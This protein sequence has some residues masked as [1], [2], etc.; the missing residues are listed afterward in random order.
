MKLWS[1]RL[2]DC[3]LI[4]L[5]ILVLVVFFLQIRK[6]SEKRESFVNEA[7]PVVHFLTAEETSTFL[8]QDEDGYVQSLSKADLFARG[9]RSHAEYINKI[10]ASAAVF[11]KKDRALISHLVQKI[12][13]ALQSY[14]GST[15]DSQKL[16][17]LPWKIALVEGDAYE[18]GYPH[19][20]ADIIFIAKGLLSDPALAN[21][22]LHEKVHIYQRTYPQEIEI[23]LEQKGYRK[24]KV[25]AAVS[26]ARSNPDIDAWIYLDPVT[27]K[28]MLAEYTSSTPSNISDVHLL[29]PAFEHPY[30]YMAYEIAKILP[31]NP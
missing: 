24:W 18:N 17:Q 21:T 14:S 4:V 1:Q 9:V 26:L 8:Q 3:I 19:T 27:Q 22:L 7:I 28:P 31:S 11:S 23:W 13:D 15:I 2:L 29:N 25:Q 10:G 12:D 16:R 5:G 20:R 30:E 6:T